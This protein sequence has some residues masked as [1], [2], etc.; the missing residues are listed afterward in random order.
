MNL[1]F[2]AKRQSKYGNN[3]WRTHSENRPPSLYTGTD[4]RVALDG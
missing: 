1:R 4:H 2:K 3:I